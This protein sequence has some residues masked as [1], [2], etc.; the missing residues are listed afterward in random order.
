MKG[1]SRCYALCLP[2]PYKS[3]PQRFIE[4]PVGLERRSL[5]LQATHSDVEI[6]IERDDYTYEGVEDNWLA[7]SIRRVLTQYR[8]ISSRL[9]SRTRQYAHNTCIGLQALLW[10]YKPAESPPYVRCGRTD[11]VNLSCRPFKNSS[12]RTQVQGHLTHQKKATDTSRLS[13]S[14]LQMWISPPILLPLSLFALPFFAS[15][16]IRK[17]C[18]S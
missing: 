2:T 17:S 15:L 3:S 4:F 18:P 6:H 9:P 5:G 10:Y 14:L 8:S 1:T 7:E 11:P 16:A 13:G 12:L